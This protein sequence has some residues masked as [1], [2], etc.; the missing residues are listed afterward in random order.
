MRQAPH[1]DPEDKIDTQL[2]LRVR[3]GDSRAMEELVLR[4]QNSVFATIAGMLRN[5]PDVEDI[6]QQVFVRIWKAASTYEPTAKFKTW[7]YTI[8]RNQ[9]FNEM[10]RLKRKPAW[11]SDAFE[12]ASGV[13]LSVDESPSPDEAV[14][15]GELQQAVEKAI[16]ELPDKARLAIQLRRYDKMAYEDIADIL[17]ITVSATKSLLFRARNMLKESLADYLDDTP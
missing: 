11:S 6:A 7:M 8:V 2:M 13:T 1:E 15:H 5:S 12:E 17:G 16:A 10:R 4:H 9:V 3:S 14:L